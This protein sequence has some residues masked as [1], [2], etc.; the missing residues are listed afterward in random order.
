M[1]IVTGFKSVPH[2]TSNDMQGLNQ[3]IFGE[4]SAVL[5]VGARFNATAVNETVVIEDGEGVIQGVHFRIPPGETD[6]VTFDVATVGYTRI[7]LLCARYTRDISTGIESVDWHVVEGTPSSSTPTAPTATSGNILNGDAVADFPL[8]KVTIGSSGVVSIARQF[9]DGYPL[10]VNKSGT[11]S[12][13]SSKEY[14][15][16]TYKQG[17]YLITGMVGFTQT[18]GTATTVKYVYSGP[19]GEGIYEVNGTVEIT[20]LSVEH[21]RPTSIV[22]VL[23]EDTEIKL[24]AVRTSGTFT[25]TYNVHVVKLA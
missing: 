15:L 23:T 20:A 24:G 25:F 2:I 1:K 5:N 21:A 7:D 19:F 18:A 14:S 17:T 10:V 4:G 12:I 13:S 22:I 8:W 3:G 16:G 9:S 6:D 11:E